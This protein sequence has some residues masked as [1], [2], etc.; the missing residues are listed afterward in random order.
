MEQLV[1][2]GEVANR[3]HV[4]PVGAEHELAL[5]G[6]RTH[7]PIAFRWKGYRQRRLSATGFGQDGHE[8]NDVGGLGCKRV[9]RLQTQKVAAVAEDDFSFEGQLLG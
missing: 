9:F 5:G 4:A 2:L 6:E 7:Q 1:E 3:F 8:A